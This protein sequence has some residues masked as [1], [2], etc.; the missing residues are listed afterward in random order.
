MRTDA[1]SPTPLPGEPKLQVMPFVRDGADA[2]TTAAS[3]REREAD[4]F[5]KQPPPGYRPV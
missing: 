2:G 4:A 3:E 1:K 5:R